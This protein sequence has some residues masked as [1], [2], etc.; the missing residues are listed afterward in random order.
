MTST[1]LRGAVERALDASAPSAIRLDVALLTRRI[2][3]ALSLYKK[4]VESEDLRSRTS[5]AADLV[6]DSVRASLKAM[7]RSSASLKT[8]HAA[9]SGSWTDYPPAAWEPLVPSLIELCER[10]EVI[11]ASTKRHRG[12]GAPQPGRYALRIRV[13]DALAEQG[14]DVASSG[15]NS[16]AAN[17]VACA[18]TEADRMAGKTARDRVQFKGSQWR[19][20]VAE[21]RTACELLDRHPWSKGHRDELIDQLRIVRADGK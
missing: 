17:V 13:L 9:G 21:Y 8:S 3:R 14:C 5:D 16:I 6:R 11:V 20:W 19:R 2:H 1:N 15:R 18:L 10:L 7:R 4:T 12:R